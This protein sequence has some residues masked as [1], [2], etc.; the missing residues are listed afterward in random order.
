M[1]ALFIILTL[2]LV[3]TGCEDSSSKPNADFKLQSKGVVNGGGGK[4][5]RCG[6]TVRL[7][8]LYEGEL[9]GYPAPITSG[10][11]NTDLKTYVYKVNRQFLQREDKLEDPTYV[12]AEINMAEQI[13]EQAI[14]IPAGQKL[15]F[16]NDATLPPIPPNCSFVQV[17]TN[18]VTEDMDS[19]L[20]IEVYRD[21]TLWNMMSPVDQ[22]A[23]AIH[24]Y[25]YSFSRVFSETSSDDTRFLIAR[26]FSGLETYEMHTPLWNKDQIIEC[27][28][29][30]PVSDSEHFQF[31]AAAE[32]E[33]G[34]SGVGIYFSMI[35]GR[36]LLSR[37]RTFVPNLT[38][39]ELISR[40]GLN[41]TTK[42]YSPLFNRAWTMELRTGD[43]QSDYF[44]QLRV[45]ASG[46]TPVSYFSL[47]HCEIQQ[48]EGQ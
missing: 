11:F 8:D 32:T 24:E 39:E 2:V 29:H 16:T 42:I 21:K 46:Q 35:K 17:A 41:A 9:K 36:V 20:E 25:I 33:Y 13:L 34:V 48:P 3:T 45:T 27:S 15:E 4:G 40:N 30:H 44:H 22:V 18:I 43:S 12:D 19:N 6:N 7:L 38:P 5:I 10:D 28:F 1:K 23:L 31:L 26:M 47:G 14:D 37:T